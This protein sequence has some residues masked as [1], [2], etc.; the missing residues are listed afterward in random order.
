MKRGA[1]SNS[2]KRSESTKS[3]K[4]VDDLEFGSAYVEY[5]K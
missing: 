1:S 2:F 3:A 5:V 4:C